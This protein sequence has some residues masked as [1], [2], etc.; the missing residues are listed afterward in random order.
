MASDLIISIGK[1]AM[2]EEGERDRDGFVVEVYRLDMSVG[3]AL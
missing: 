3:Y 2:V 1:V